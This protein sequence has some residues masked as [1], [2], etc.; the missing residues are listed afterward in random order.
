[1]T[2]S[3]TNDEVQVSVVVPFFNESGNIEILFNAITDVFRQLPEYR[4][5]CIFVNDGSNDG[6][7]EE[8]A[9]L[10]ARNQNLHVI[11]LNRNYG[12]SAALVAGLRR[13]TGEYIITLDGDLQND[14]A[15]IPAFLEVLKEVDFVCG[16]RYKRL[17]TFIRRLSSRIANRVRNWILQDGLHDASCGIKG[18][19]RDCLPHIVAFN[20]IHRF[21][22]AIM[23]ASG[24]K[25]AE[26]KVNHHP[27]L[28]GKS[29]YGINNRLWRGIYDLFGMA[30]L[31]RRYV[32]PVMDS[33][34]S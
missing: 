24:K 34:T 32:N 23:K 6:T 19:R 30:W 31:L 1:M 13:A 14:P 12:Q 4:Y 2:S 20:G 17:D 27:R 29:K 21:M 18:F 5:E 15:D 22:G 10:A 7:R 25:V 9:Q 33:E 28:H 16:Y 8:L 26:Y 3:R 11:N